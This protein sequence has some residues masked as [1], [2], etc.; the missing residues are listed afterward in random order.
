M[1]SSTGYPRPEI[2]ND[3]NIVKERLST[4]DGTHSRLIQGVID[5]ELL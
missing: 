1:T 4:A 5:E 3:I 2:I